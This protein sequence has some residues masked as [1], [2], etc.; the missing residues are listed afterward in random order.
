M[1]AIYCWEDHGSMIGGLRMMDS[2]IGIL[3]LLKGKL[4]IVTL[5][6]DLIL[7][8]YPLTSILFYHVSKSYDC[9]CL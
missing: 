9:S 2:Q 8:C 4:M 6:L 3:S 7:E 1:H 5:Y